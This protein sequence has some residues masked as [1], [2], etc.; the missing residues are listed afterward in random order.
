MREIPLTQGYVALVDDED[1][2]RII[3]LAPWCAQVINSDLVYAVKNVPNPNRG[4]NGPRQIKLYMH[5][6][7]TGNKETDHRNHVG[8]DNQREN[9]RDASRKQNTRNR[10]S[11]RGSSSE[12]K[13][14]SW[15]KGD[16]RWEV[17]IKIDGKDRHLGNFVDE[18]EAAYVY[19]EAARKAFGE[20]AYLNFPE[21]AE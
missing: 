16:K 8:I 21:G 5:K 15:H 3:A 11:R 17:Q 13:G 10:R 14:V 18:V 4:I 2:D 1:Y 19:D 6:E 20:F 9:L 12:F 7:I